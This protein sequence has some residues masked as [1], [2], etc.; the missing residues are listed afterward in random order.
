MELI[1]GFDVCHL[2]RKKAQRCV[3]VHAAVQYLFNLGRHLVS[4]N[5]YRIFRSRVFEAWHCAVS[6]LL[7]SACTCALSEVNLSPLFFAGLDE[8]E[9][10][11][12]Q[13]LGV[14]SLPG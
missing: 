11:F 10:I 13:L 4:A 5:N 8:I 3:N 1:S 6:Y 14:P 2:S 12:G 9:S 7:K